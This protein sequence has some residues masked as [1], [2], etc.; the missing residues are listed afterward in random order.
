MSDKTHSRS[1]CVQNFRVFHIFWKT[2]FCELVLG[3]SPDRNQ[4]S[5]ERFSGQW[6]LI[7]I[8]KKSLTFDLLSQP[9]AKTL[10][11]AG[12]LLVKCLE[13]LNGIRYLRQTQNTY[14]RVKKS[15]SS[16]TWWRYKRKENIKMAI[17]AT[18]CPWKSVCTVLVES[19]TSVYNDICVSQKTWPPLPNEFENLL[20]KVNRGRS[21]RNLVGLFGWQTQRSEIYLTEIGHW[22]AISYFSRA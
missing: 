21:E 18:I 14:V 1:E 13:L 19:A 20:E 8:K 5:A 2:Y 11:G 7:F 3:F 22:G 10:K 9:G 12:A 17:M 4:T 6:I 15:W 16:A